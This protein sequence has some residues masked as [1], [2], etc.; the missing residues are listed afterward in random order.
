MRRMLECGLGWGRKGFFDLWGESRAIEVLR[1]V[2]IRLAK[3]EGD[4]RVIQGGDLIL[5]KAWSSLFAVAPAR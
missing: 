1:N 4:R 5:E 2:A 3:G